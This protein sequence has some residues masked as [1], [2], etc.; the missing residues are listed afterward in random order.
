[1][2]EK[3]A[4]YIA[5][6]TRRIDNIPVNLKDFIQQTEPVEEQEEVSNDNFDLESLLK[7]INE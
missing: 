4:E 3:E 2:I 1:L 6:I 5:D 7:A